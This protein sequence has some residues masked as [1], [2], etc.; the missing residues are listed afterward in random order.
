[1]KHRCRGRNRYRN[2]KGAVTIPNPIATPTPM[3]TRAEV[4]PFFVGWTKRSVST[5]S[6]IPVAPAAEMLDGRVIQVDSR[7]RSRLG[8]H[9]SLC[10]PYEVMRNSSEIGRKTSGRKPIERVLSRRHGD[11][12][13]RSC[14]T[15]LSIS[16][17]NP[18]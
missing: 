13:N 14:E 17:H 8:G 12:E 15:A 5:I 4:L 1:M 11:T 10:P 6:S 3:K 9:A 7:G 16:R 2:R 18:R